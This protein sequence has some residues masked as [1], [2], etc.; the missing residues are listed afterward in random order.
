MTENTDAEIDHGNGRWHETIPG[1]DLDGL[2]ERSNV[3]QRRVL[4]ATSVSYVVVLLDTSI[5]NVALERISVSLGT[6]IGGLQWVMNAYTLAF[7]CLL[8]TGGTLGDRWGARNLYLGGLAVFTFASA[9]CGMAGDLPSLIAFRVLQG[10]GAAMLVPCS[11]K[12]INHSCPDPEQRARAIGVWVGC[13]GVAMAAGPL[14]GGVLIHLLDWRSIF[15]VN[16][17]IGL[18]GIWM[19]WRI[20]RDDKSSRGHRFDPVGQLTA[21]VALGAL[22]SVLIEG[23]TLGWGSPLIMAGIAITVASGVTFLVVEARSAH[24]MLPL[25]FFKNGIFVGSTCVSM[26]SAFVFYGLLFVVSL[27]YQQ[28]RGYLPLWA[29]F[30][31]LPMTAMVAIGS[32][33]SNRIVKIC[34]MRGSMCAAF[35]LYAAGALGMLSAGPTSPYGLA[36]GP[37]LAIGLASGFV[38][39][40]ATAPALGTVEKHR[41]GVAA[42]VL[43][44]ARQTG[45][46]LGVALFGTL[47]AALQ[48][49]EAG[50][51]AVLW[52]AAAVSLIA[53]FV[54]WFTVKPGEIKKPHRREALDPGNVR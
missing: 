3:M 40:A 25:S 8:L 19:T 42:A 34:G 43:N 52:T 36:L 38:S 41:A 29:G 23:R 28:A 33:I 10:V 24:P 7:A 26:A 1:R 21:I 47:I 37:M 9:A 32:I 39:P 6:D 20:A 46:A 49:F 17:P 35:G 2:H 15:F 30:A 54:W 53:G 45:A 48:S 22:I 31:F 4:A 5:I 12:L 14:V 11:L 44:S 50:M 18:A 16:V 13:G 51:H 27:Y